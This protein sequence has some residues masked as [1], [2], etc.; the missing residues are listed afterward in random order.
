MLLAPGTV[1]LE[2]VILRRK[3]VVVRENEEQLRE[4]PLE[5][6]G[7]DTVRYLEK[8]TDYIKDK[9]SLS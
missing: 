9:N 3:D 7:S 5:L 2:P 8:Q 1:G 6:V 4:L